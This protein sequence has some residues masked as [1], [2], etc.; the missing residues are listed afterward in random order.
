MASHTGNT[1]LTEESSNNNGDI[2]F[3]QPKS[4]K[5]VLDRHVRQRNI[6]LATTV[7]LFIAF[8]VLLVCFFVLKTNTHSDEVCKTPECISN[9]AGR[10]HGV[11]SFTCQLIYKALHDPLSGCCENAYWFSILIICDEQHLRWAI[12]NSLV[13]GSTRIYSARYA[14][15]IDS[16]VDWGSKRDPHTSTELANSFNFKCK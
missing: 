3:N 8:I 4:L 1:P 13:M 10:F 2:F 14:S 11:G 7:V 6:L 15:T 9:A 5:R 12:Y 16:F